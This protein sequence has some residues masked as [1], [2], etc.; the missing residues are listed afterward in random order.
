MESDVILINASR[1]AVV[2]ETAL[3]EDITPIELN[4]NWELFVIG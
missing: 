3:I 2:N 1:G 4:T